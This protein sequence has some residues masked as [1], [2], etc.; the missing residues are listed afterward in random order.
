QE[1]REVNAT[2]KCRSRANETIEARRNRLNAHRYRCVNN[3][4]LLKLVYNFSETSS[5]YSIPHLINA[6]NYVNCTHCNVLK[7]LSE[8][9]G[10][11][12]SNRK[13]ILFEPVISL[14]LQ[15][16][17]S[18]EDNF[19]REF[20]SKIHLYN[21]AF[22]FTSLGVKFDH[23]LANSRDRVYTYHVQSVFY[24]QIGSL[25]LDRES[26]P[27]YLQMLKNILDQVNLYV[28]NFWSIADLPIENIEN[29]VMCI[30]T[31]ISELDQSTYNAPTASQIATIWVDDNVSYATTQTRNIILRTSMGHLIRISEFSGYYDP[32]AYSF[33]FSYGKQG[34]APH[35]ILYRD[36]SHEP[37]LDN[38]RDNY[39][40][41]DNSQQDA[42]STNTT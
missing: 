32:I 19:N 39:T 2:R 25:L 34:W 12:C 41:Y 28:A 22:T 37:T 1:Q 10:M 15:Q 26:I 20:L 8:S 7:L 27:Q 4:R 24:Y 40:G 11:C 31:N 17:F 23:E 33:L 9:S 18:N 13:V 6:T 29:L 5:N 16:L 35:Q 14:F 38:S 36:F 30:H 42:Y 21:T 3:P